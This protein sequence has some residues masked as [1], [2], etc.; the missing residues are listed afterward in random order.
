MIPTQCPF[1]TATG[2]RHFYDGTYV[3][4]IWDLHPVSPGHA[5]LIPKRH[6]ATWFE[7]SMDEQLEL[8][9]AISIVRKE[10]ETKYSPDGYNIG[11]NDGA[12]AGQTVGHL[13]IHLIPR[14]TGDQADPRGGVR[15]VI[16][17]KADYWSARG[18]QPQP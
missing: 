18:T 12:D 1:C 17:E 14:Y 16:P 3:Y 10:I 2:D 4:G 15:W 13:H 9:S 7:A 8:F 11:I 5:L 6:V